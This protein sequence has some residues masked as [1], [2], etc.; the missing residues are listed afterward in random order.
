MR[1]GVATLSLSGRLVDKLHAAA[2][3]GFDGVEVFDNDLIG[4]PLSPTEV[5]RLAADLGLT[6][7]LFQPVRDA[8]GVAPEAWPATRRRV[9][10]KLD[11]ARELGAPVV[12]LCSHVGGGSVD[13]PDLTA[14]QLAELGDEAARRGLVLAYEALAWGRHVNRLAHAWDVVRRADHRSVTLAVDTFHVL[15]RGDDATALDGVPGERIG[16]LQVADA[17]LKQMDVLE[18]SRHFR[19]FPGQGMLDVTGVVAATLE[20]GYRGPVSLEVFSDVVR[21]SD[22]AVTARDA[23]RSLVFLADELAARLTGPAAALVEPAPP[24]PERVGLA[25]LEVADP[26]RDPALEALLR[27]LG[28]ARVGRHRSKPVQ[29]WRQ[30]E[31][32]V[33]LNQTP[34]TDPRAHAVGLATP[35]VDTVAARAEALLWPE[36]D[37]TRGAGEALLPGI[38]TPGETHLFLSADPGAPDHWQDDFVLDDEPAPTGRWTGLDHVGLAVPPRRLDEEIGFLRTVL[39]LEAAPVEEFW[40]PQGRL[41]SRALEPRHGGARIVVNVAEGAGCGADG[42]GTGVTQVAF[43]CTDLLAEVRSLRERGVRLMQVPDNYYVDLAARTD[44]DPDRIAELRE[45]QVLLDRAGPGERGRGELLHVYTDVLAP[46]FYVEL[47]ERRDGY[48]GYGSVNTQ[49]RLAVQRR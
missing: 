26:T 22:Q 12:L 21:E 31:A 48:A 14:S 16:F 9:V 4:C 39:G 8:A 40:E 25:F 43:A 28:F 1:T 36:V 24:A 3:A 49:L 7:D 15:A 18:W 34:G 44:L 6:I 13:D 11:V 30:G 10:A 46:G 20:A 17:P 19:C 2:A 29:W 38:T 35:R 47:L 32:H 27:G 23:Y 45:H 33:V 42:P 37:R 41:R 5:A